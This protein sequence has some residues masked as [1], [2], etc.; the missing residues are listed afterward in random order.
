V[1]DQ[2]GVAGFNAVWTSPQT[3]PR[4][5]EIAEPHTWVARVHG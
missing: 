1:T 3:L 5:T 4:P 2:V